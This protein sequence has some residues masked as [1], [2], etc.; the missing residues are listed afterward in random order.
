MDSLRTDR[1]NLQGSR[2]ANMQAIGP[3]LTAPRTEQ[4]LRDQGFP[5]LQ[6]LDEISGQLRDKDLQLGPAEEA[7]ADA[8]RADEQALRL[9]QEIDRLQLTP[10]DPE[11][12]L[13][14]DIQQSIADLQQRIAELQ[15]TIAA[16]DPQF[17]ERL[18]A[19]IADLEM[20]AAPLRQEINAELARPRT[21][22]ELAAA[23][24]L[25][26]QEVRRLDQEIA[27]LD[28]RINDQLAAAEV[29]V[30]WFFVPSDHRQQP[31]RFSLR[32]SGSV[33]DLTL[34]MMLIAVNDFSLPAGGVRGVH[35]ADRPGDRGRGEEVMGRDQCRRPQ[36]AAHPGRARP[37]ALS[38]GPATSR[39]CAA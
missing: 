14:P 29:K 31:V 2:D 33:G 21:V 20:Q 13:P 19:E 6:R 39:R 27:V 5:S 7:L 15:L 23:G 25:E 32:I 12:Q 30:N 10:P 8:K 38:R 11:G 22:D 26:A 1:A 36:H 17:V 16:G 28:G 35:L 34:S 4:E 37:A 9:Q 24:V 3:A 18:K